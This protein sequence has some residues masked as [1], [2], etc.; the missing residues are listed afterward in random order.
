MISSNWLL[1]N[2]GLQPVD[3]QSHQYRAL[4]FIQYNKMILE[5]QG[6]RIALSVSVPGESHKQIQVLQSSSMFGL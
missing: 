4:F 3:D 5:L 2:I 6:K 1:F